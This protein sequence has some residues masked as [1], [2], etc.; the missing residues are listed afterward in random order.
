[1]T[2]SPLSL[3]EMCARTCGPLRALLLGLALVF[4]GS[5]NAAEPVKGELSVFTDG[6]FTRLVFRL[7]EEVEAKVKVSGA[8]MVISFKQPINVP[9]DN[10]NARA[11]GVISAA[12]RDPDGS[13]IRIAL[14]RKVKVNLIHA[15]ERLYV[16]LLPDNWTGI[17]PGLPQEV[18]DELSRRLREAERQLHSSAWPKN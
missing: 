2:A 1:M 8:I 17:M 6:G 4:A 5:A 7:D 13:A 12:R 18:V 10:L 16:D 15:A 11:P 14:A 9:V 3:T